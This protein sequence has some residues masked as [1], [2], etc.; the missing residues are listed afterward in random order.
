MNDKH[1]LIQFGVTIPLAAL[2]IALMSQTGTGTLPAYTP[3]LV[4]SAVTPLTFGSWTILFGALFF[5]VKILFNINRGRITLTDLGAIILLGLLIDFWSFLFRGLSN[6][7]IGGQVFGLILA[8]F[9]LAIVTILQGEMKI[10]ALPS[11]ALN[12]AI[13]HRTMLH[14]PNRFQILDIICLVSGII[15]SFIFF[16]EFYGIGMATFVPPFLVPY[17]V[18]LIQQ[19]LFKLEDSE[20]F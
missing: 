11:D 20:F 5:L 14:L 13:A 2:A 1:S 12:D 9:F 4:L 15:L 8:C 7:S 6:A 19:G 16:Q 18:Y 10:F 17:L 3:A